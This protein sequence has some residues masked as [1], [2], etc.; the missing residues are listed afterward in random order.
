MP[1]GKSNIFLFPQAIQQKDEEKP[2]KR[3]G[4][5]EREKKKKTNFI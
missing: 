2:L 3:K 1:L 4:F 5:L